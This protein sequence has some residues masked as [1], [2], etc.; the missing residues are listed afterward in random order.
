MMDYNLNS[1]IEREK[2]NKLEKKQFK[3]QFK[4]N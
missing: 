1:R 3:K 4:K 2:Q